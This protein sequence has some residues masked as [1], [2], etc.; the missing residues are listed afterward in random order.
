MTRELSSGDLRNFFLQGIEGAE[1]LR[2]IADYVLASANNQ[3]EGDYHDL[4]INTAVKKLADLKGQSPEEA[5]KL[6]VAE[7][8]RLSLEKKQNN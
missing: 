6:L 3:D 8:Q 7:M 5:R 4:I 1:D 2:S